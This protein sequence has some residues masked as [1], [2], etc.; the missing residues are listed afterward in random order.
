M[1]EAIPAQIYSADERADRA[2][3]AALTFVIFSAI[4]LGVPALLLVGFFG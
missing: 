2:R 3:G 1:Q 4:G